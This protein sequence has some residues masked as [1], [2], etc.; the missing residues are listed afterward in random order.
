MLADY[1]EALARLCVDAKLRAR[2]RRG[3]LAEALADLELDTGERAS[4][5][6]I[7]GRQLERFAATLAQRRR[8]AVAASLPHS[9]RLW[10][11][12]G[13]SYL[14]FLAAHPARTSDRSG[15][16]PGPS[17]AQRAAGW[18]QAAALADPLA[19]AW[20]ADLI[21]LELARRCSALDG[22][23]RRLA[24]SYPV[25]EAL[26]DLDAGWLPTRLDAAAHDYRVDGASLSWRRSSA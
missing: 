5:A 10:P 1:Q 23:R 24:C 9:A 12:L 7:D 6:A 17:E 21:A 20:T 16:P 2:A 22:Q 8:R 14:E 15:L 11:E 13:P 25:H 4:L 3:Q 26:A 19:P 18:L